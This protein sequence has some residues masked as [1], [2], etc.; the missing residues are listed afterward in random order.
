MKTAEE[1]RLTEKTILVTGATDGIG[2]QTALQL[3]RLGVRVLIHGRDTQRIDTTR[4]EIQKINGNGQLDTF[5]AD[6][7][8][9]D[10]VK[11]MAYAIMGKYDRL[12][13]LINN[14]GI[15]VRKRKLTID[16]NEMTFQVNHLAP[17]LLTNLLLDLLIKSDRARIVTVTSSLHSKIILDFEDLQG[18]KNYDGLNSYG[19]SKLG[20]IYMTY[21]LAEKLANTDVTS[22]C[23][24][25]GAVDT[26]LLRSAMN[27]PGIPVEEGAKPSVYLASS[28]E[29]EGMT[30]QY[31][32]HMQLSRSS[33]LSYDLEKRKQLWKVSEELV[34]DNLF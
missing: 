20:N 8:S 32:Y 9:L 26:K 31:F 10:Q 27:I 19:L 14:A 23:M 24:H 7:S 6:F 5:I 12:D 1:S 11:G 16:G 33:D 22:N 15:Y 29:V 30:G 21:E 25:P 13:G 34:K 3:A 18:E 2:K 4:K 17:F 28:A